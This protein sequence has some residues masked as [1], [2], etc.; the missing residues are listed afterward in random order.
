MWKQLNTL[1]TV[2]SENGKILADE[3]YEESW[4]IPLG[5]CDR[6]SPIPCCVSNAPFYPT[7]SDEANGDMFHTAFAD[8]ANCWEKY[9]AMRHALENFID[10]MEDM[11][12]DERSDFYGIFTDTYH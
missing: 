7:F 2:G 8:E 10:R 12:D 9:N 3:E 6:Y 1:G 11:S 5:R 4:R